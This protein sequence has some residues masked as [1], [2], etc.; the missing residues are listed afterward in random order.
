MQ[1]KKNYWTDEHERLVTQFN[2][3]TN[4]VNRSVI[5]NR[6]R[7]A[8]VKMLESILRRYFKNFLFG[9][10][11]RGQ[12]E[13][14]EDC[15]IFLVEKV[16]TKFNP[17]RAKAYGFLGTSAKHWFSDYFMKKDNRTELLDQSVDGNYDNGV[18]IEFERESFI[19]DS[20]TLLEQNENLEYLR[21]RA[22]GHINALI[23]KNLKL[24]TKKTKGSET[25]ELILQSVLKL[26]NQNN[27]SKYYASYFLLAKTKMKIGALFTLM[28]RMRIGGIIVNHHELDFYRQKINQYKSKYGTHQ[29]Y[30]KDALNNLNI[31]DKKI[32]REFKIQDKASS[33]RR[34]KEKK[35]RTTSKKQITSTIY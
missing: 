26:L 12:D 2:A 30:V 31:T 14:I 1:K 33:L 19:D 34:R 8:L 18:F 25:R 35:I 20:V 5:Y 3:E 22:I 4:Q 27:Y 21:R 29:D 10:S 28:T 32:E 24:K 9:L 23:S 7:P 16:F 6:L 17:D 11:E 15:E 13:I